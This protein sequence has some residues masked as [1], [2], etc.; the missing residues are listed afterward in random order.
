MSSFLNKTQK[1]LV[2]HF[3]KYVKTCEDLRENF[4]KRFQ[5]LNGQETQMNFFKEP[6]DV[7]VENINGDDV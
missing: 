2:P 5:D 4:L 7:N 1:D 3:K 6:F